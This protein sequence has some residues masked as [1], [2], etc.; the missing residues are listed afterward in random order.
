M[1]LS[2]WILCDLV[3]QMGMDV[4]VTLPKILYELDTMWP[5]QDVAMGSMPSDFVDAR[6]VV[7]LCQSAYMR[8]IPSGF[9]KVFMLDRC[10]VTWSGSSYGLAVVTSDLVVK[11]CM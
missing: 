11:L 6:G 8:R 7:L 3:S 5:I 10:H 2:S 9:F 4:N 1:N